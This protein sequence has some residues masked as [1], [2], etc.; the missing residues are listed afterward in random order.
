MNAPMQQEVCAAVATEIGVALSL[1]D[2]NDDAETTFYFTDLGRNGGINFTLAPGLNR[3]SVIARPGGFSKL[4]LEQIRRATSEQVAN[5][6]AHLALAADYAS[7]PLRISCG[8]I[9]IP[10]PENVGSWVTNIADDLR[11]TLVRR[12]FDDPNSGETTREVIGRLLIPVVGA[13]A[14]LIGYERTHPVLPQADPDIPEIEGEEFV[15]TVIRRE[16]SRLNRSMC[17]RI[18]GCRCFVCGFSFSDFYGPFMDGFIEVHHLEPV[19]SL[20]QARMYDPATD[21]IPLCANCHRAIHSSTPPFTPDE[22]ISLIASTKE[23][24]HNEA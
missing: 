22:L 16:R 12:G 15:A 10:A 11:I 14:E 24:R 9:H 13:F 17:I 5:A 23:V 18:H 7:D 21:L 8:G 3:F 4:C 19:S 20:Q 2:T 1:R 6:T